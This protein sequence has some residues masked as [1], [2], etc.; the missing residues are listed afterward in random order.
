LTVLVR[1][2]QHRFASPKEEIEVQ[3]L[4][5]VTHPCFNLV[6]TVT[7]SAR[8]SIRKMEEMTLS[9]AIMAEA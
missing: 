3:Y 5:P 1:A 9:P 2:I 7:E 6:I 4:H 8:N